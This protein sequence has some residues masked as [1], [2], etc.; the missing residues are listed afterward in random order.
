MIRI[1]GGSLHKAIQGCTV[2]VAVD[3]NWGCRNADIFDALQVHMKFPKPSH[4]K[5]D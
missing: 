1:C 3:Q 4:Y 2:V 5:L